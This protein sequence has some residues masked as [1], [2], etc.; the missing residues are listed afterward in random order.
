MTTNRAW[1]R[2]PEVVWREEPSGIRKLLEVGSPEEV[3]FRP[4]CLFV[5]G[6]LGEANFFEGEIV[7]RRPRLKVR[8]LGKVFDM[9]HSDFSR[10]SPKERRSP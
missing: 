10:L 5:A 1:K 4:N 6:F 7:A 8:F 2:N 9:E 3:Y